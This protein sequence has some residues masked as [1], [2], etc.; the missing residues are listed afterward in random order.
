MAGLEADTSSYRQP[1]P[2]SPLDTAAKVGALEQ[3]KQSIDAGKMANAN[4]ALQFMTRAM[5]SLGPDATKEEYAAVAD[6]A[7]KQGLVPEAQKQV[8][9]DRLQKAPNAKSFFNEFVT[10]AATLQEQLNYHLGV[11]GQSANGQ[12][13]TPT[14][15]SVKPGFGQRPVGLPVQ[16]QAPPTAQVVGPSGQPQLLGA[17][18]PQLAP[19]TAAVPTPLPVERPSAA[20]A[21]APMVP[22]SLPVERVSGPTGPTIRRTDM[23]P[24]TFENRFPVPTGAATGTAPLFEEGKQAY[25]KDQLNSSTRAQSIKPAIQA[26]KLMTPALA[27]GPGTAQFNDLVAAAK[28]WGIVD[29]K[30]ENDPTV[31]RQELEKK[32]AQYVGGS[33]I[34]QRSDAAQTLAEA[35]S[36]NPKKQILPALQALTRDAIALDRVQILKPQAFK[37]QKF[38]DYIKHTGNFPQSVDEKALTLDLMDDKEREKLVAKMKSEYKNGDGTA[39]KRAVKFFETL[40]LARDAKLYDGE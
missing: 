13:V 36:P 30:A 40:Q 25:T 20:P 37:G 38:D 6:N 21:T 14:V 35:G 19:G 32:L 17:Q 8:Y 34:A 29:T 15:T 24:T 4:T 9:M 22:K 10:A 16:Q 18:P 33:P 7:V 12:T 26:L 1:L 27:T 39:K 31:M 5:T 2:V 3:Q 23:E 28:A 11:P